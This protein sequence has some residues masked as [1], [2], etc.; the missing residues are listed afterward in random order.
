M[1]QEKELIGARDTMRQI[2][3]RMARACGI[4]LRR[5]APDRSDDA[6]MQRMLSHFDVD[7]VLD[8]GANIGQ[9]ASHLRELGYKGKIVSFE[10]LSVAHAQ[11]LHASNRDPR[12]EV[13][14]RA[15]IGNQDGEITINI[16]RNLASSSSLPMLDYHRVSAPESE[17]V[18]SE[19]VALRRLDTIA[20]PYLTDEHRSVYLKID[21]Q[22]MESQVLDGAERILPGIKG[23]QLELS[24]AP[25][26]EGEPLFTEM[27]NMLSRL[28]FE[29][30]AVIP[31]FTDMK[32]GRLL[33]MDGI[34][35]RKQPHGDGG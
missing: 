19:T 18:S 30:F 32:S 34:F 28:G 1:H 27:L 6:R 23:I 10:P 21:V 3:K 29:L 26:Y 9:Y 35:F 13:A 31:G 8:V 15:A 20:P 22:G 11:L 12:W 4:E 25:L 2:L 17:Y 7:L 33:Q 16:S 24:L 5:F 14:P